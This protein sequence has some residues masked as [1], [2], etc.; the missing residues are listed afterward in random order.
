MSLQI[1]HTPAG[2]F[3]VLFGAGA[4]DEDD[5]GALSG[6]SWSGSTVGSRVLVSRPLATDAA[7]EMAPEPAGVVE[8]SVAY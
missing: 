3:A 2:R 6:P 4:D 1:V 8:S 5:T 7:I